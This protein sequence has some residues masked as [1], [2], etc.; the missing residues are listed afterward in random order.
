MKPSETLNYDFFGGESFQRVKEILDEHHTR[1]EKLEEENEWRKQSIE[2]IVKSK[3]RRSRRL[4]S[5]FDQLEYL[6]LHLSANPTYRRLDLD[7]SYRPA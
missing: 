5:L 3:L 7:Q 6:F 4:L 1:L 2:I